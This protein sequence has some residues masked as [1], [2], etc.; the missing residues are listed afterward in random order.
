M[1]V[2]NPVCAE[3]ENTR[4]DSSKASA[5]VIVGVG[6]ATNITNKAR[7]NEDVATRVIDEVTL[8]KHQASH[9]EI[10]EH[11]LGSA[12]KSIR[13]D[14]RNSPLMLSAYASEIVE[15]NNF[16]SYRS[17]ILLRKAAGDA[18]IELNL[19]G[20]TTLPTMSSELLSLTPYQQSGRPSRFEFEVNG[21]YPL[22]EGVMTPI[23][24]WLPP[25]Q[26]VWMSYVG[27]RY[28]LYP[29]L[30]VDHWQT[31][32]MPSISDAERRTLAPMTLPGMHVDS[33]RFQVMVGSSLDI[34][35]VPGVFVTPRAMMAIPIG[36]DLLTGSE[37]GF[38]WEWGMAFGYAF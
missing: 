29:T 7:Q 9:A 2:A 28:A 1:S 8:E 27:F 22:A 33:A 34:Y 20:V 12:S 11:F 26:L 32:F 18:I 14:W 23:W 6:S 24:T 35:V 36:I 30:L 31:L 38:W 3:S 37:L 25:T 17:G 5:N 10:L 16:S 15:R 21:G 19:S 13:F 4:A